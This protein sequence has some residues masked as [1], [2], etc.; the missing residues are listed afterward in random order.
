MECRR[1]LSTKI[2]WPTPW[3]VLLFYLLVI[4]LDWF[5][6]YLVQT[7]FEVSSNSLTLLFP[8]FSFFYIE[9]CLLAAFGL[10]LRR[11]WGFFLGY[12]MIMTGSTICSIT[13]L[14]AYQTYSSYNLLFHLLLVINLVVIAYMIIYYLRHDMNPN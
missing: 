7:Q 3:L 9:F 10:Y 4:N 14:L 6:A 8:M 13:Y 11:I 2:H 5:Y 12:I 1:P